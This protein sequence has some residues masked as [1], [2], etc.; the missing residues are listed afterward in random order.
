MRS[1]LQF[2]TPPV[3][4]HEYAEIGRLILIAISL[5]ACCTC[6]RF[7]T[8]ALAYRI[9]VANEIVKVG[10]HVDCNLQSSVAIDAYAGSR[11][12]GNLPEWSERSW[13]YLNQI[14]ESLITQRRRCRSGYKTAMSSKY[15]HTARLTICCDLRCRSEHFG[16]TTANATTRAVSGLRPCLHTSSTNRAWS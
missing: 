14:I 15:R 4:R 2:L 7:R 1:R 8:I 11:S 5:D 13:S 12:L 16:G 10:S 6:A 9:T 3:H